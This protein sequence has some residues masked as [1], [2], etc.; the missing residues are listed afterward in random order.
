[1]RLGRSSNPVL[2]FLVSADLLGFTIIG[3]CWLLRLLR[4][5]KKRVWEEDKIKCSKA[6]CSDWDSV[7]LL[8]KCSPD[9]WKDLI[10]FKFLKKIDSDNPCN[11][12]IALWKRE[13]GEPYAL[14]SS[15]TS[16]SLTLLS[17]TPSQRE[18]HSK[19]E[20]TEPPA[21]VSPGGHCCLHSLRG[22][23]WGSPP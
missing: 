7:V 20:R 18:T 1:M 11:F 22:P 4:S 23:S 2:P 13:F 16:F 17:C 19:S 12:L 9:C 3:S 21:R 15:P 6:Y 10:H 5:S 14:L 8:N